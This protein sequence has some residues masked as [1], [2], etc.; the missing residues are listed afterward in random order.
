MDE[1]EALYEDLRTKVDPEAAERLHETKEQE[2]NAILKIAQLSDN[3][4][5]LTGAIHTLDDQKVFYNFLSFKELGKL[6]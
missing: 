5:L 1:A 3:K 2:K 6:R 4:K